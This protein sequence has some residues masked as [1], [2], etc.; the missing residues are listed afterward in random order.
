LTVSAGG[1]TLVPKGHCFT[2]EPAAPQPAS[3]VPLE[4]IA[5]R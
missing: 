2:D 4:A 1:V 5:A 3:G